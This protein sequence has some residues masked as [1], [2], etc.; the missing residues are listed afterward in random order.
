LP[1]AVL[2]HGLLA[3]AGQVN[4]HATPLGLTQR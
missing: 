2:V 1:Y 3:G 4:A